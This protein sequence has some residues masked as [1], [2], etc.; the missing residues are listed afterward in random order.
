M[1]SIC[2]GSF[3]HFFSKWTGCCINIINAQNQ[4]KAFERVLKKG[5]KVLTK[6]SFLWIYG[7]SDIV[8]A[9]RLT[10]YDCRATP[11]RKVFVAGSGTSQSGS[12][13][14]WAILNINDSFE[15]SKRA[16]T[17][18]QSSR[19]QVKTIC[20]FQRTSTSWLAGVIVCVSARMGTF[21]P[22]A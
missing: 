1:F 3:R 21:T 7:Y 16:Q 17:S 11:M 4:F 15:A 18:F 10:P 20:V 2:T 19:I 8:L 22:L 13:S 12:A 5:R 14:Q 9:H 6:C